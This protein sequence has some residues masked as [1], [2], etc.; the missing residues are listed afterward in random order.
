MHRVATF[1]L[2]LGLNHVVRS[3]FGF[4]GGRGDRA[5]DA[6]GEGRGVQS[7]DDVTHFL[8]GVTMLVILRN[9]HGGRCD[10]R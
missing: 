9:I 6:Y 4:G 2:E 1:D 8:Q 5:N 3:G 10:L 7:G